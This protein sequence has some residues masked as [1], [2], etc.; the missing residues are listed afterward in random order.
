MMN[1]MNTNYN[2]GLSNEEVLLSRKKYG[3]N[4][5]INKK[6]NSFIR[7]VFESLNDP[8]IKILLIALCIK[9]IFLFHDSNIYETLGIAISIFL[10][11][12]IS[13]ISEYGSEKAFEKLE[14]ENNNINVKVLRDGNKI[15]TKMDD[16]VVGDIVYLESGDKVP[17]DGVIVKGEIVVDE[18]Y[19][20]GETIEK[21]KSVNDEVYMGSIVNEKSAI[22]RINL[23]GEKTY[24]G[25]IASD[26][27]EKSNP[28]PLKMKLTDLAKFISK[29]GYIGAILVFISY[30]FNAVIVKYN[31]DLIKIFDFNIL[32][33]HIIYALTLSVAVVVMAVPEGL[34]MMITLV[35]S[36]NMKRLLKKNVLVR[37]LVGIEHPDH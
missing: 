7:L 37:K 2:K 18:S 3:S 25:K 23:V 20:T 6:K 33:P 1:N 10:A 9:I 30:I 35:L 17:A 5:I 27:Q 34:P 31:F 8:I 14:E 4:K 12:F 15:I 22:L 19:L 28:S 36:S 26:I 11:S 24:Y 13:A 21:N 29:I 32:F 16:I